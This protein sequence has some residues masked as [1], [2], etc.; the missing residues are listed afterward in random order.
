MIGPG[1]LLL[2]ARKQS[3]RHASGEGVHCG[4]RGCL[5]HL[6]HLGAQHGEGV[7]LASE[8]LA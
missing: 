4:H 5:G 1:V 2:I 7:H 3:H 8:D 6:G